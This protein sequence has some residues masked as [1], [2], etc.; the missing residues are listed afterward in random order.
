MSS[1]TDD[2]SLDRTDRALLALLR[3]D[4]RLS[5]ADLAR[6]AG[7]S[8]ASIYAHL[9]RMKRRGVIAGYTVRLGES[10]A[11]SLVRAHVLMKI[12]VK[13]AAAIEAKLAAMENVATLHAISGEYDLI[14]IVE[15]RDLGQL[16][17]LIDTIA[18]I[19]G[20]ERTTSSVI[21]ATKVDR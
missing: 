1:Q 7:V 16:N 9:E 13:R 19:D 10:Y 4:A 12:A 2:P 5:V 8:R 6:A 11:R 20:V 18:A 15:A 3:E 14:G 17:A 21:L